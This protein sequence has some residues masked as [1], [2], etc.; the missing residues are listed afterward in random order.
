MT[1][2][3]GDA[4]FV[5]RGAYYHVGVYLGADL[6]IHI[7]FATFSGNIISKAS[8][9]ALENQKA[10]KLFQFDTIE[11]F[12]GKGMVEYEMTIKRLYFCPFKRD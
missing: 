10:G 7:R 12:V 4:L 11:E 8:S 5:D 3:V 1:L 2:R 6:V 9:Y